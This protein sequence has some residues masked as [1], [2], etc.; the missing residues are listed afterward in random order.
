MSQRLL[1]ALKHRRRLA[2][3]VAMAA[4]LAVGLELWNSHPRETEIRLALSGEH[5]GVV[6]VDLR[7]IQDGEE[8]RG[9]RLSFP[10]GA[11]RLVPCTIDLG[12]GRYRMA[13]E[14]RLQ[15]GRWSS[16]ERVLTVP[17]DAPVRF[18]VELAAAAGQKP[19]PEQRH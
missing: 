9:I 7:F 6:G 19:G 18:E 8:M 13:V 4:V 10:R 2:P 17:A 14:L 15:D 5:A 1:S 16:F 11:P 3:L 12:P